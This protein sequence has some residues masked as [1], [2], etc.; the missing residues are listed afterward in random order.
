MQQLASVTL[1]TN[2]E[3]R[4]EGCILQISGKQVRLETDLELLMDAP[5]QM[6]YPGCL[7]LGEVVEI[8]KAPPGGVVEVE[9]RHTL[10]P[11]A[12]QPPSA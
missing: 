1:L 9:I 6:E 8:E 11:A 7:L 5:V 12:G 2:P 3:V 4:G 10:L